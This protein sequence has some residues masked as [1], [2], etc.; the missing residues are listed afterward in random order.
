MIRTFHSKVN[1]KTLCFCLLPGTVLAVYFFWVKL[2]LPA[3]CCMVFLVFVVERLIH[4]SYVFT[5]D[6][7]LVVSKGR[8]SRPVSIRVGDIIEV[9]KMHMSVLPQGYV[10]IRYGAGRELSVQ[11]ANEDAFINEIRRRQEPDGQQ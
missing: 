1:R 3:L 7:L 11:P 9:K 8:F 2:P 6:G 4:T 10:L 5:D